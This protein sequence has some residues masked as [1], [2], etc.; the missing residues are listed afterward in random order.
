MRVTQSSMCGLNHRV[1]RILADMMV[2]SS[3]LADTKLGILACLGDGVEQVR[4]GRQAAEQL[5]HVCGKGR[6]IG[7]VEPKRER[8][9]REL[10]VRVPVHLENQPRLVAQGRGH[11]RF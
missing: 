10:V 7:E 9:E 2:V 1:T 6:A 11:K 4:C 8:K 5:R 3:N